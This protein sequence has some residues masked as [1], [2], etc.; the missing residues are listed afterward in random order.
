MLDAVKLFSRNFYNDLPMMRTGLDRL[1]KYEREKQR[2]EEQRWMFPSEKEAKEFFMQSTTES[3]L[4]SCRLSSEID[5]QSFLVCF[6]V[7]THVHGPNC[8]T[9]ASAEFILKRSLQPLPGGRYAFRG[10]K[11]QHGYFFYN[12]GNDTLISFIKDI[13]CPTIIIKVRKAFVTVNFNL[14]QTESP[15]IL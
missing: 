9:E 3:F 12:Y 13:R 6:P 8:I 5:Q 14:V 2:G 4:I 11:R 1:M 15:L 7:L 10:D